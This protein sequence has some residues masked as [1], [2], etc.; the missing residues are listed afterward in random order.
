MDASVKMPSRAVVG[1]LGD[2]RSGGVVV[3]LVLALVGY[4]AKVTYER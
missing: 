3:A 4:A 2:D 1:Q